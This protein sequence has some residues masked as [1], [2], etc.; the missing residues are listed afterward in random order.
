MKKFLYIFSIIAFTNCTWNENSNISEHQFPE[1]I[2]SIITT[3]CAITGC[4]NEASFNAAG[5]L[6]LTTWNTLFEGSWGGAAVIPYRPQ[7]SFFMYFIHEDSSLTPV[8]GPLMPIN[9][10]PL[11]SSEVYSIY[12][13]IEEGAPNYEGIIKFD[14]KMNSSKLFVTNQGCDMIAVFDTESKNIMRVFDVGALNSI[15]SP[16]Y[17]KIS[18]DGN[19]LY[20]CFT[21]SNVFQKFDA[22]THELIGEADIT[23]GN[24]NTFD[25]S[26]DGN[27]AFVVDWQENGRVAVVDLNDMSNPVT[28]Q[29]F[30]LLRNIHGSFLSPDNQYL[31]LTAQT[32][33]FVYKLDIND[34]EDPEFEEISMVEGEAP[35]YASSLDIHELIFSPDGS[36]YYVSC[37][38][39]NEIRVV[40]SNNDS[41]LNVISTGNYPQE[42][43]V[44]TVNPYLIVTCTEDTTTYPGK[45]GSVYII[46]YESDEIITSIFTGYQ[47]HG[48]AIDDEE[49]IIY[50]GNRNQSSDGP[51]PHH[52]SDCGGK[53]G[54]ISIIDMNTLNLVPGYRYEVLS[55][56]YSLVLRK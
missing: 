47:P 53:N 6:N 35:N 23:F 27:Y 41:L 33:N 32:G 56:P 13:W 31:Y 21:A 30:G 28:Y 38:K 11:S 22:N 20:V 17:T 8:V 42:L 3:K 25:V 9:K 5:G 4:H 10:T 43:D 52:A 15:E 37:Q 7:E 29:G 55:D 12:Q 18:P 40:Q 46:N 1:E 14:D 39:S 51:A 36:K 48:L 50:I 54:Y 19:Y 34:I 49:G 24:W 26:D 45:R 2:G 44:S 16:H